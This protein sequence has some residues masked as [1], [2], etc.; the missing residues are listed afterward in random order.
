[1]ETLEESEIGSEDVSTGGGAAI[2]GEGKGL[3]RDRWFGGGAEREGGADRT[4]QQDAEGD[5]EGSR[6]RGLPQG[7][8]ELHEASAERV[9]RGGGLG[10]HRE[11][12]CLWPGR[13]THRRGSG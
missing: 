12:S 2:D 5:P 7:G 3:D 6:R 1:M 4:L 13:G 8:G 9:Q 10:D 11:T